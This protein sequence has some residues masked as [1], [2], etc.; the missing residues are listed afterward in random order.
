MQTHS[1]CWQ[2]PQNPSSIQLSPKRIAQKMFIGK[3]IY[4]EIEPGCIEMARSSPIIQ[5]IGDQDDA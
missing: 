5:E 3:Y 2:W 1:L 4:Q